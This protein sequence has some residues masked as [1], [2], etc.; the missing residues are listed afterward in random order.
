MH[1][2]QVMHPHES[3]KLQERVF[4]SRCG[5]D[6]VPG[7]IGMT[8]VQADPYTTLVLNLIKNCLDIRAHYST[9]PTFLPFCADCFT[10][11][12]PLISRAAF[13]VG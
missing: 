5:L 4:K 8:G 3:I 7:G 6:I 1:G 2:F 13:C 11:L 9:P 10:I 12:T